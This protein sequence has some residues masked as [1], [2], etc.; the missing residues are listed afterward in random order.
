MA[1]LPCCFIRWMS[2][3]AY[4]GSLRMVWPEIVMVSVAC[5]ILVVYSAMDCCSCCVS[6]LLERWRGWLS[7]S[8]VDGGSWRGAD[9]SEGL[10]FP[11]ALVLTLGLVLARGEFCS[12]RCW[13]HLIVCGMI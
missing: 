2:G 3:M 11:L 10:L 13:S 8:G 5:W 9:D 7:V 1:L 6:C 4:D 12:R